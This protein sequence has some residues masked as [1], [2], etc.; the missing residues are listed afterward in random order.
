MVEL[1][2]EENVVRI[3]IVGVGGGGTNAVDRMSES[4][5]PLVQYISINTDDGAVRSSSAD[6]KLQ[7][8]LKTTQG[9]GAG[10]NPEM[11]RLSAQEDLPRIEKAIKDC[12]ML[13]IVSGMGG[14]TGTGAAPVV[15]K[16]AKE[17]GI[18]TVGVVTKPFYFEG[19]HR[20]RQAEIGIDLLSQYVDS[21]IEIPN[22]NLKYISDSKL[23][24]NNAMAIADDVLAQTVKN[25]VEVIQRTA[26]VNCDFADIR[27][28]IQD[29]GRMHTAT[30][31]AS[32]VD[33]VENVISQILASKLLGTSAEGADG[34]LL[35]ITAPG[36][37][38]LEEVEKI[39]SA[40]AEKIAADGNIIFGMDFDDAAEDQIKAVLIATSKSFAR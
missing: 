5:I 33:R 3:N 28:V 17:L 12:D 39:S 2:H 21:I 18:L 14:G 6:L 40:V 29:S 4:R 8:G 37:V 36:S 24:F 25:I 10:A 13:F 26:V 11:G 32:G 31:V 38:G 27:S 7:I 34:V 35:C 1:I 23:T 9:R 22:D 16:L 15:A 30:G 20:M 19:R